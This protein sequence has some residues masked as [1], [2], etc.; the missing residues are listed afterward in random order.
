MKKILSI[1]VLS[2]LLMTSCSL[3]E[4]PPF[5]SDQNVYADAENAKAAL[6]GIYDG[7]AGYEMYSNV[8]YFFNGLYSGM[9]VSRRGGNNV[10]TQFN[11]TLATM[12]A[13]SGELN[14]GRVW[15]QIYRAVARANGAIY[16]AIPTADPSTDDELVIN[17]VVGHAY[18]VRAFSYYMLVSIWGEVPLRLEPSTP[19]NTNLAVS[20]QKEIY[21]QILLD[22]NM[23]D[24]LINGSAGTS[25]PQVY[26]VNML[27]AKVYMSLATESEDVQDGSTNYWQAAY[28]EAIKVYGHYT[29]V[30]DY[31]ELFNEETSDGTSESIFELQSSDGASHDWVR[32]FTPNNYTK[33]NTFGWLQV[34][35]DFYNLHAD[36]Y[37]GDQ[38]IAA[39]YLSSWT[40]QN[41]GNITNKWPV[42][43][44]R[45]N[46]GNAH[47][48]FFKL[49]E[50]DVSNT[51]QVGNQNMIIFRYADLLLM[52]AEISN[53]LQNGEQLDY[54]TEVLNRVGLS[55]QAAYYGTQDD[56]RTAVM[57]EYQ[58]ELLGEGFDC[59][60]VRRRGFDWMK[61]HIIDF[62]N[63]N[64][65]FDASVD[66]TFSGEKDKVME[67]PI[68]DAEVNANQNIN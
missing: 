28:D 11:S 48:F 32:A 34:N 50:K 22:C 20:T 2:G 25:F 54:V 58:F 42:N 55:P 47:P 53:E 21:D 41:N 6:N 19:D 61:T 7:L 43:S 64:P 4:E 37:P 40:Q 12:A 16:S 8:Y 49:A 59:I 29:L 35:A 36:T 1:I 5:L 52:L 33:A 27:K 60:N 39:T 30:E 9:M 14:N 13:A 68:P 23:A 44:S 65:I 51:S 3:E 31:A 10:N 45:N 66:V 62:H 24:S 17:D 46:F 18:F 15:T 67:L 63:N 26:A 57:R 56:F 38:R